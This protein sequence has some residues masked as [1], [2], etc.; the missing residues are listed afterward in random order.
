MV[1]GAVEMGGFSV[2]SLILIQGHLTT[3]RLEE[4]AFKRLSEA[5]VEILE[6]HLLVCPGCQA[7]LGEVDEYILLMKEATAAYLTP[8]QE[9]APRSG[10]G[11]GHSGRSYTGIGYTA[12]GI[13]LAGIVFLAL[14]TRRAAVPE[15]FEVPLIALRGG[16]PAMNQA[17]AGTPLQLTVD[18]TGLAA[19]NAYRIE[20]V[21]AAG[22]SVWSGEIPPAP[23][24]L[25]ARIE[26]GLKSGVYWVRLYAGGELLREFGLLAD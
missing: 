13:A 2:E 21:D 6:E 3:D 11:R 17:R 19:A 1:P 9:T 5:E 20:V 26:G 8:L 15:A 16:S 18:I 14:A 22:K 10:A 7:A 24:R 23:G 25:P 4:Y 12:G